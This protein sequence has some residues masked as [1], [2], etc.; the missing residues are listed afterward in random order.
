MANP[1]EKDPFPG[2][3]GRRRR[4]SAAER[5]AQIV[6]AAQAVFLEQGLTG[7]RTRDI[8][9]RAGITEPFFYRFFASKEE[10]YDEAVLRP[11]HEL[12]VGLKE[13]AERLAVEPDG[14]GRQ[15]LEEVNAVLLEFM[16]Q[17]APFLAVVLFAE[18]RK[19]KAF[20]QG[21]IYRQLRDCIVNLL[22]QLSAGKMAAFDPDIVF[23]TMFG[24]HLG[25]AI[26]HM[27]RGRTLDV[28]QTARDVTA[29][30]AFGVS[31]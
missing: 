3:N 9:E 25:V 15:G 1:A 28:A 8:T 27:L 6:E 11:L 14:Q 13:R 5:R 10:I 21:E 16:Q 30:H 22:N 17:A 26:D 23:D 29:I 19:G 18:L 4:L 20:Y 2:E 31:G 24:L 12:I 7:A